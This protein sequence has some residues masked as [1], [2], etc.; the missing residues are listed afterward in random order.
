VDPAAD[1]PELY[2]K[3]ERTVLPLYYGMPYRFA[4]VMRNAIALNGSFFNTQ[5]MVAQYARNAYATGGGP[6]PVTVEAT[7]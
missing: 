5:R 2:Y 7:R 1:I 6:L 4:E 3:L